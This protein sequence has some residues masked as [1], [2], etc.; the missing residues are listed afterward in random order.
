MNR[1]RPKRNRPKKRAGTP[2]PPPRAPVPL[3]RK[4]RLLTQLIAAPLYLTALALAGGAVWFLRTGVAT[5]RGGPVTRAD[6]PGGFFVSVAIMIAG[7]IYLGYLGV[8]LA[9][10]K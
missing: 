10:E 6:Q 4:D 5:G 1:N 3:S 2:L 7:A 9:R 8:N